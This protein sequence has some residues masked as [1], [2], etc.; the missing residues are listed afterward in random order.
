MMRL[1]TK[2]NAED[3]LVLIDNTEMDLSKSA[4]AAGGL[5]CPSRCRLSGVDIYVDLVAPVACISDNRRRSTAHK[6]GEQPH[7]KQSCVFVCVGG[8]CPRSCPS[9][10]TSAVL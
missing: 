10:M 1:M 6:N 5:L 9:D 8:F 3:K 7:R 2:L 4:L